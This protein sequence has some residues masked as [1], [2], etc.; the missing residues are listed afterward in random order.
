MS[1]MTKR[2][3]YIID[4]IN[5]GAC[6]CT[7]IDHVVLSTPVELGDFP[8]ENIQISLFLKMVDDGVFYQQ[9]SPPFYYLLS[10]Q[11]QK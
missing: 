3:Q 4:R 9:L 7:G 8:D 6:L 5:N 1:K 11:Y 2:R 10:D